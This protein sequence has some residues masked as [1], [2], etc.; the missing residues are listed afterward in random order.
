VSLLDV[1]RKRDVRRQRGQF[2][3]VAVT[4]GLGVM[5]FAGTFD[6]YRNLDAS[7]NATYDR[8][9]FADVTVVGAD[10]DFEDVVAG[11]EGVATVESRFEADL[12]MRVAGDVFLGRV[13]AMPPD[14]QPRINRISITDGAYLGPGD[15]TAVVLETHTADTFGVGV[16][17]VVEILVAGEW[18][19]AD[20]VGVADSAEYLWP[21]RDGQDIFPPPR[22]FGVAFVSDTLFDS[23]PTEVAKPDVLITYRDGVDVETVDQRVSEAA[24]A[25]GAGAVTPRADHP[26]HSTLVLDVDGF[27]SMAIMFPALFMLA[28]GMAAFVLL[29]RIVHAQRTQ[30]GTLRASGMGRTQIMRHYLSYGVRL[31]LIAGAVGLAVGM[32]SG[33]AITGLYTESLGIPDTERS[34]HPIT[35]IVGILFGFAAGWLGAWAPARRAMRLSPA[36]AMRGD[37]PAEQG[38]RSLLERVVPPLRH[39]PVR[40]LMVVRGIGRNKRR[41]LSTIIGVILALTLVMVSWGMLDTMV[42]MLDRQFNEVDLE[43]ATVVLVEPVS[44]PAVAQVAGVGG[45]EHVEVV[46]RLD[47]TVERQGESFATTLTGYEAGTLV[48]GF[49]DGLPAEGIL[50]GKGLA[51]QVGVSV[52]DEVRVELPNLDI[53]LTTTVEGF[54]DEPL[55][56]LLYVDAAQLERIV[57]AD[58][59][60]S[61]SVASL[62][63]LFTKDVTDREA[64]I[65]ELKDL[66]P[67]GIA[68][69]ARTL[70]DLVQSFLG[71]FYVFIGVM[72]VFGGAMAFAL[73]YNTISVNVAERSGEFA[74][75]RANGVSHAAI[76][77][78]IATENVLLTLMGIVPGLI[79]G[80][81]VGAFFMAQFSV[82]AF[83]MTFAMRPSSIALS[84]VAMLVVAGLSLIP[85]IR[86][87]RRLDIGQVVRERAA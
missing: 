72:L 84:A 9:N 28:A 11:L 15:Q 80:Y 45:I 85:A 83:T 48:H 46:A 64:V 4:I 59:I 53:E 35:P 38:R 25:A 12:P 30:I 76:A 71:F 33:Y 43:D 8:L 16:G 56:S 66:E 57:G 39:L 31:G 14:R 40:W 74:T 47:A 81:V 61:P 3:A 23:V 19:D 44:D 78:L 55:G 50:A 69:D 42:G 70:Y 24:F 86:T 29:N 20:V 2:L 73:M 7:Y 75:M 68:L 5:L 87:V 58:T 1:K 18:G 34:F 49:P 63:I 21:A 27:R 54:L 36:E 82:D 37:I 52:G 6:P 26:S 62:E 17:D 65:D 22:T 79:I 77:R 67:V 13:V 41:S 60:R 51:D 32:V 10:P